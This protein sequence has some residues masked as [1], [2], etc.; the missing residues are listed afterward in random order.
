M[1]TMAYTVKEDLEIVK[2]IVESGSRKAA[3][4]FVRNYRTFV[5]STAMRYL[6]ND[7]DAE[8]AAQEI[9]I[10]ALN[11]LKG[12]KGNSN[13]KTWL[14]RITANHCSNVLRKRKIM[15]IF[16]RMDRDDFPEVKSNAPGPDTQYEGKELRQRFLT[17]LEKLPKKQR[18]TFALR[19]FD[20][21]S[22]DE[23]SAML[24]TSI[25]GLKANYYQAVKKLA[26]YLK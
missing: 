4:E 1:N 22:Y 13:I 6:K 18:E 11:N 21:L 26:V 5:Y 14:Y 23:I 16:T 12:F 19:Y 20:E 15:S 3:N 8:D 9:F 25:G 24:G 7:E 17:A 2:R 10:K